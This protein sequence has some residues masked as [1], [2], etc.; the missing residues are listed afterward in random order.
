MCHIIGITPEAKTMAQAF[1]N[2]IIR[3]EITITDNDARASK[4]IL[5]QFS[6][7]KIDYISLGC[8]HYHIDELRLIAD[9]LKGKKVQS[10]TIVH[11]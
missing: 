7:E 1:G 11:L 4:E 6:R 3:T 2:D 8:P 5:N 9:Y 10:E